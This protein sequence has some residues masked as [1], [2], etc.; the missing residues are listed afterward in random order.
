[1][2]MPPKLGPYE[3]TI[4]AWLTEG[5]KEAA[6]DRYEDL[7]ATHRRVWRRWPVSAVRVMVRELK[8]EIIEP[9]ATSMIPQVHLRLPTTLQNYT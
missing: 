5:S 3:S 4:R 6:T 9:P 1:M 8:A 7:A 2:K